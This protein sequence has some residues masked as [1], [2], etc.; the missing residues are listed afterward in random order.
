M[1]L[2]TKWYLVVFSAFFI[3]VLSAAAQKSKQNKNVKFQISKQKC[4]FFVSVETQ[5]LK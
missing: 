3:V 4:Q 1:F 5:K 2:T